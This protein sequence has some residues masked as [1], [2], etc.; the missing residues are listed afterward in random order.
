M[1][2]IIVWIAYIIIIIAIGLMLLFG[3]WMFYPYKTIVFNN[4]PFP[5]NKSEYNPGD[6]L[7]YAVDYCKYTNIIPNVAR[8]YVNGIIYLISSNP[9]VYKPKGCDRAYVQLII[10]ESLMADTYY[11]KISYAYKVNPI[12]TITIEASTSAFLVK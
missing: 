2:K 12:R 10:P 4:V 5:V 8:F 11:L 1:N 7:I 3:F 9:A 6:S